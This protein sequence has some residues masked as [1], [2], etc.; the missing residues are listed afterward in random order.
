MEPRRSGSHQETQKTAMTYDFDTLRP[1][2]EILVRAV[3]VDPAVKTAHRT[4]EIKL[5]HG[6]TQPIYVDLRDVLANRG[7][8]GLTAQGAVQGGANQVVKILS[9]CVGKG[10]IRAEKAGED[11]YYVALEYDK[12]A[13]LILASRVPEA[14]G[15]VP[16][17]DVRRLRGA[18]TAIV[19]SCKHESGW[20]KVDTIKKL[21]EGALAANPQSAEHSA[22]V[23]P[24]EGKR[25]RIH[26]HAS[27][28]IADKWYGK[29]DEKR[30]RT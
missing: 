25:R 15:A 6:G 26:G 22:S 1:G 13:E 14:Q 16:P 19:E 30:G 9:D 4:A 12:V 29:P 10:L 23:P 3:V 24:S 7:R 18:L 8:E 27:D 28:T 2:Q 20:T 21:A 17:A 5:P 11:D